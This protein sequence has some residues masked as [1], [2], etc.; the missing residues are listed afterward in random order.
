MVVVGGGITGCGVALDAA[1]RGLKTA[2]VEQHD[3]ASGTSS[4]SSKLVHGGL[5]YLQQREFRLVYEALA[6]RQRLINNAPHLVHPLPFLVPLFGRDGV[7]SAGMAKAYS[8][9]LWMYDLTG[10]LR[11]GH[12]HR[13]ISSGEALAHFPSLRTDRLVA[14][15]LYWDAQADDARLT[16]AL[17]RTAAAHGAVVANH[18]PVVGV[19]HDPSGAH[20]TGVRLASGTEVRA[21]AVVNASGVW[22]EEVA[23]MDSGAPPVAIRPAKGIHVTVPAD[24][25]PCDYASVLSVPGDKRTV[26]VVPWDAASS[27]GPRS[28]TYLGTTDT[29]YD[30]PL[31]DPPCTAED[32]NYVLETV[33]AWTDAGVTAADVTGSWAGLRPLV[34][35]ASSARTADLSRRHQVLRSPS[36]LV[37]VTGGKL[38]TYRRMAADT[39]D[40]VFTV[41][42]S[43]PTRSPTRRLR[44]IGAPIGHDVSPP[45]DPTIAHL[46]GR[47]GTEAPAV[48]AV[49]EED[50]SLRERLSEALPYLR[51]EVVFAARH[52][53]ACTVEDVLA[54]RLRALMLHRDAAMAAAEDVSRILARELRWD[55]GHR[56]SEVARFAALADAEREAMAPAFSAG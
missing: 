47:Y 54:R 53:M 56:A 21:R 20:V 42:G 15:F 46:R 30:G 12:R 28:Y 2:L 16:L 44:L 1:A 31:D 14:S 22:T 33:N 36:G 32:V 41:L 13:R 37:S 52:E 4:R 49:T 45:S 10:G 24:R 19:T 18:T 29:D 40:A 23:R 5:R 34:A 6:E 26:F 17:A 11:I 38:T 39:V 25:L 7:V 43:R 9:A 50:S 55:D 48:L 35:G 8:T 3:F 27:R 51:A